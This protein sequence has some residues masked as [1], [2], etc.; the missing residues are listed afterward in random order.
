M[1][2]FILTMSGTVPAEWID[3]NGHMNV[4]SYMAL[5]DQGAKILL[6]KSELGSPEINSDITIVAGRI[7][8]EHKKELLEGEEWKL[9]SGFV[10]IDPSFITLTHRL[11]SG[12][13]LRAVC[14]I[15]AAAF[16]KHLRTSIL[17][18]QESLRKAKTMLVHGLRDRFV[19]KN[20]AIV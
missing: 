4:A 8:I 6:Q 2:G 18:D 12:G 10:A 20:K 3:Y 14:D 19:Q 9:W 7:F 5:F 17:L 13:S 16:S 15:R 1:K 11:H